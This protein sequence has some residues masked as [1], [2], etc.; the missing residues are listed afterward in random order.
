MYVCQFGVLQIFARRNVT[1][2]AVQV[3][4]M[5]LWLTAPSV[6]RLHT[7][8]IVKLRRS[9]LVLVTGSTDPPSLDTLRT[10]TM[11]PPTRIKIIPKNPDFGVPVVPTKRS[12][13]ESV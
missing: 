13:E 12:I 2:Y 9:G 5:H 4:S 1:R 7:P 8:V 3:L 11:P 6:H 10:H